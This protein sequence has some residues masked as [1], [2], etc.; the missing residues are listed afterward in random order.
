MPAMEVFWKDAGCR[1]AMKDLVTYQNLVASGI[2]TV[3][4]KL[5]SPPAP[6]GHGFAAERDRIPVR[7]ITLI[8]PQDQRSDG[9]VGRETKG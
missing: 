4:W 1:N 2:R 6:A 3:T 9:C 5:Y 7:Q 8:D